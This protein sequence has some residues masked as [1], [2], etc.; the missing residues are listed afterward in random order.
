M[1]NK[2]S[3]FNLAW[4]TC[5]PFQFLTSN[6]FFWWQCLHVSG[7]TTSQNIRIWSTENPRQNQE[8]EL[9]SKSSS[10]F[11]VH[12]DGVVCPLY[13]NNE[14]VKE[15]IIIRCST[16]WS[17]QKLNIPQRMLFRSRLELLKLHAPSVFS[18]MKCLQILR[19][20][21][22]VQFDQQNYRGSP[23]GFFLRNLV[24]DQDYRT[25][26]PYS[27]EV[28]QRIRTQII[29]LSQKII[30]NSGIRLNSFS[31]LHAVNWKSGSPLERQGNS[32]RNFLVER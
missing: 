4:T 10:L 18:S 19:L 17:G 7:F 6:R 23:T 28:E 15:S 14:T 31:G 3:F 30:E 9:P 21:Y 16:L 25:S 2:L 26:V 24:K 29:A 27:S 22:M 1:L 20:E 11:A 12:A 32:T 8:H 5:R 13:F